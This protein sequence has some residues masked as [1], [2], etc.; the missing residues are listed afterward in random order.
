MKRPSTP[1][2]RREGAGRPSGTGKF[3]EP[4]RILRIPEGAISTVVSYLNDYRFARAIE[5]IPTEPAAVDPP[6]MDLGEVMLRVPAGSAQP[7]DDEVEFGLDL[8]RFM[9]RRADKTRIYTVTG[10]S[11]DQTGIFAGDKLVVDW[12]LEARHGDIVIAII[13]GEGHTVKRL[14]TRGPRP[15]LVPESSNPAHKVRELQ[16]GDEWMIWAVVTGA[17]KKFR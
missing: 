9:V 5:A 14:S 16:D 15:K 11:M 17:L 8:N 1:G 7:N 3:G 13:L 10:D 12:G 2:G 6:E 4:T